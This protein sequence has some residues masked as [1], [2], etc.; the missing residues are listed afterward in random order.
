MV[1]LLLKFNWLHLLELAGP[2]WDGVSAQ[3]CQGML[4]VKCVELDGGSISHHQ[5][6]TSGGPLGILSISHSGIGRV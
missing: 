3:E 4:A 6:T 5:L 2:E 1:P